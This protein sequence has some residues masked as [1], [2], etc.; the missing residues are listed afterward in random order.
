MY[1]Y[2]FRSI[3]KLEL[4]CNK[5]INIK[6]KFKQ[7]N[8]KPFMT[9]INI[10]TQSTYFNGANSCLLVYWADYLKLSYFHDFM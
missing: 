7:E 6:I 9:A 4:V 5:E 2:F 1:T 3:F 8:I 10:L